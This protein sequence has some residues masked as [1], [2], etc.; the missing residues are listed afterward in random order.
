MNE[1]VKEPV[2]QIAQ[3]FR[4][5][6][7]SPLWGYVF[8]SW[9]S[10]NWTN[11]LFV[12]MSKED[13]ETRIH[14]V[15]IQPDLWVNYFWT[16]LLIGVM[17]FVFMPFAQWG[18]SLC[19]NWISKKKKESDK[20]SALEKYQDDIDLADKKIE[21]ENAESLS[22]QKENAKK[23]LV[24]AR[25]QTRLSILNAR[26][27]KIDNSIEGLKN[28]FAESQ[29]KL[30]EINYELKTIEDKVNSKLEQYQLASER[31]NAIAELYFTY[32]NIESREGFVSFLND[33][34]EKK[35]IAPSFLSR[36]YDLMLDKELKN[37]DESKGNE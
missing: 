21:A 17:L 5:R 28:A 16:P 6:I 18:L 8:F 35:L 11:I 2:S 14:A 31:V 12:F 20:L 32:E 15:L 22:R 25:G 13:I 34:K 3:S 7:S 9:V 30:D 23:D 33:I 10:C 24:E 29:K 27:A 36:R 37:L 1:I 4:D 26:K 19:H